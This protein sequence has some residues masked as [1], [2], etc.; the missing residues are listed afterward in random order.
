MIPLHILIADDE[1]ILCDLLETIL[2]NFGHETVTAQN[3]DEAVG[4]LLHDDFDLVITD[5]EMGETNG[6]EVVRRA[7]EIDE[8]T[9]VFLMTGC[10]DSQCR[11]Q[12]LLSGADAFL[13]KPFAIDE[14]ISLIQFHSIKYLAAGKWGLP[15]P[16]KALM[17]SE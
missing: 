9:I 4:H 17:V 6:L 13:A 1:A 11:T 12:A 14:L 8:T 15:V 16:Q 2:R 5:L 7:K 3:G 10:R